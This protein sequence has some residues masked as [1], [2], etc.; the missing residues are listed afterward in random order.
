[1]MNQTNTRIMSYSK[2]LATFFAVVFG[3]AV[4]LA[5]SSFEGV[6]TYTTTN[7]SIKEQAKVMWYHK[8]GQN[9]MEFDSQAGDQHNSYAL[10]MGHNDETVHLKTPSGTQEIG[11]I[12]GEEVFT[13]ARY[14]RKANTTEGAYECE[15]LMFKS[16][17]N[18]LTYWVTSDINLPYNHLPKLMR[19]N[20]PSF[21][22]I[23]NGFPLKMEL[24][25]GN[26]DLL[27][28]QEVIG[29][30]QRKVDDS[31]FDSK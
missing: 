27:R 11:G 13:Q 31:K 28:S 18:D 6:I 30:E 7:A 2:L 8:N 1:M 4:T 17:G 29:V 19:N 15:M 3:T 16:G 9:L 12:T 20:M 23:S 5:Q 10:I 21:A 25:D 22:G 26:G 24:R 14:I